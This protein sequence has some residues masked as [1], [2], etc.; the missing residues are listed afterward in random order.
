MLSQSRS[1]TDSMIITGA[2]RLAALSPALKDPDA[3][4][5]PDFGDAPEVN[6]QVGM[7]VGGKAI[8]E[9]IAGVDWRKEVV[10]EKARAKVW[11]PVYGEYQ[12]EEDGQA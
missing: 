6:F 8:E 7:A 9:G 1:V 2:R 12:H 3:A 10:R 11:K 4:L 5:L